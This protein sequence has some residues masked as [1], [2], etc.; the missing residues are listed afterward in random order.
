MTAKRGRPKGNKGINVDVVLSTSLEMLEQSGPQGFSMRT[1][2]ANL[3]VTPMALYHYFPNRSALMKE[4]SDAVYAQVVN[5]FESAEGS[6]REKINR[7][8]TTYFRIG[9]QHPN[10]TIAIFSTPEAFSDEVKRIT[11][12]LA[13]LLG[14]TNLSPKRQQMWL[15]I[16]VDFTHGS[17]IATAM[18]AR[19]NAGIAKKQSL[20]YSQQLDEILDQIIS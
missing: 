13:E 2:A 11:A 19:T 15:D 10:L 4:L 16:L 9:L 6:V 5:D 3:N 7:L 14:A 8:L 20:R 1:L 17:S 18:V 12:I